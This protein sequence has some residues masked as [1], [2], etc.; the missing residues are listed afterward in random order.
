M[1]ETTEDKH[2]DTDANAGAR[3]PPPPQPPL[4]PPPRAY[5]TW[6]MRNNQNTGMRPPSH[7]T[8]QRV[9]EKTLERGCPTTPPPPQY[10]LPPNPQ[11]QRMMQIDESAQGRRQALTP[12]FNKDSGA[13]PKL[14]FF[15]QN[16]YT[17]L[18]ELHDA[19]DSSYRRETES[20]VT[21]ER[22]AR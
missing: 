3:Y 17:P 19:G 20:N 8:G 16:Y 12:A 10:Q 4:P 18:R 13:I 22:R 9:T 11:L 21:A 14:S 5:N 2:R 6:T 7:L 15:S 1:E